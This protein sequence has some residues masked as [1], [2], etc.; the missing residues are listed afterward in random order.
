MEALATIERDVCKTVR[1]LGLSPKATR[2]IVDGVRN[3]I[4]NNGPEWLISRVKGLRSYYS[5]DGDF[6]GWIKYK[7]R[8][9]GLVRPKGWMGSLVGP[10]TKPKTAITVLSTV[11]GAIRFSEPTENQLSKW[12]DAVIDP[13]TPADMSKEFSFLRIPALEGNLKGKLQRAEAFGPDDISG[14]RIPIG[15][16]DMMVHRGSR[17]DPAELYFAFRNTIESAP[18]A[19]WTFQDQSGVRIP[20]VS[21]K[22]SR[23]ILNSLRK[24]A[25]DSK[26]A[27]ANSRKGKSGRPLERLTHY[28]VGHISFLQEPFG[29]LRTVANPNRFV[30]WQLIPLGET[31]SDWINTQPGIYVLDQEAGI[32]WIQRKLEKGVSITSMDLSSASDTLDFVQVSKVLRRSGPE[33]DKH[34]EYFERVSKMDWYVTNEQAREYVGSPTVRWKQGQPLGLRPSFPM[35]TITNF[36][37]ARAAVKRVDGTYNRSNPPFAIVGDDI[38]IE[39]RYAEAYSSIIAGLG[40]VANLEKS[41]VS[42]Y[43]AEFCSRLIRPDDVVRLKARYLHDNDP[44]NLLTYQDTDLKVSLK[45]WVRRMAQRVGSYSLVEYGLVPEYH[46]SQPKRIDTKVLF[47]VGLSLFDQG[48]S[49]KHEMSSH[50]MYYAALEKGQHPAFKGKRSKPGRKKTTPKL[51]D[52]PV[53]ERIRKFKEWNPTIDLRAMPIDLGLVKGYHRSTWDRW[54]DL[55]LKELETSAVAR[56]RYPGVNWPRDPGYSDHSQPFEEA[57]A[58]EQTVESV[59]MSYDYRTDSHVPDQHP[60]KTLSRLNR[61]V[62]AF[63]RDLI[64]DSSGSHQIRQV[65]PGV[66]AL[67][68]QVGDSFEVSFHSE[69]ESTQPQKHGLPEKDGPRFPLSEEILAQIREDKV[70][71]QL[72]RRWGAQREEPNDDQFEL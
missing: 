37:A 57:S 62:Q 28:P 41:M 21:T 39:T 11:I 20:G 59:K 50:A 53:S 65:G 16:E 3:D 18:S 51:L 56:S 48:K 22:K 34:L 24:G 2:N 72:T 46:P 49:T 26:V 30:Q 69:N 33:M 68:E 58:R 1:S 61:K 27:K 38:A 67:I 70:Q 25:P 4:N 17:F 52:A 71:D 23:P 14:S 40:G 7:S 13:P 31:L 45:P 63:E 29:K 44:Q 36:A 10:T 5:G 9:D 32:S 19:A 6:P 66:E 60:D 12:K 47:H 42:D 43:Q 55:A 35:L 64:Q 15:F 54:Q 8:S